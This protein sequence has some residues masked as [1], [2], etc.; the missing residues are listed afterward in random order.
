[1]DG[2]KER[3]GP[4]HGPHPGGEEDQLPGGEAGVVVIDCDS[5]VMAGTAA[6]PDCVV[7]LW[8]GPPP[9]SAAPRLVRTWRHG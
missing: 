8:I 1:M 7:S 3:R 6:C 9:L 4:P 2:P 5:C